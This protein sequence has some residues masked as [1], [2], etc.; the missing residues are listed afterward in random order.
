MSLTYW[1]LQD[2]AM[3]VT[4]SFPLRDSV[5]L[6]LAILGRGDGFYLLVF[7]E[8]FVTLTWAIASSGNG[9]HPLAFLKRLCHFCMGRPA[10]S[11]CYS[12]ALCM[13]W[14]GEI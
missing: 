8:G 6:A 7:P 12:S 1:V 3:A 5:T 13:Q 11:P 10:S 2:L 9:Q 4:L 14:H